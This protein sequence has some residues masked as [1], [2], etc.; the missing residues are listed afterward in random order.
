M[1]NVKL[2]LHLLI[3]IMLNYCSFVISLDKCNESCDTLTKISA[4]ICVTNK[5]EDVNFK[6]F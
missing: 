2:D 3:K 1:N 4:R 5:T 6:C